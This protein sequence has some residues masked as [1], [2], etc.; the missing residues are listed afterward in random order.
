MIKFNAK[1]KAKK[2]VQNLHPNAQFMINSTNYGLHVGRH[3]YIAL[4]IV[5]TAQ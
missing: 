1:K 3:M 2:K 4:S 5:I